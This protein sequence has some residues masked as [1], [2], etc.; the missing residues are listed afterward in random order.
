M[1]K[2]NK[3][4]ASVSKRYMKREGVYKTPEGTFQA[5]K[6]INGIK[7]CKTFTLKRNAVNYLKTL[8][9]PS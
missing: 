2:N 5:R 3:K 1:N 8:T 9:N 4:G 6:C 7:F